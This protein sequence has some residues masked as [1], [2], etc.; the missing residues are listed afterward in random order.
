MAIR[1]GF[2]HLLVIVQPNSFYHPLPHRMP[3]FGYGLLRLSTVFHTISYRI[4]PK[5]T[6]YY[7]SIPYKNGRAGWLTVGMVEM[8]KEVG[9]PLKCGLV[10]RLYTL[11][12]YPHLSITFHLTSSLLICYYIAIV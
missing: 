4:L 3:P 2:R 1:C 7:R 8:V 9:R 12:K 10:M 5:I 6:I 11:K